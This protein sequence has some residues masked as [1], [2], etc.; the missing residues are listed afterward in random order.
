MDDDS[1]L[2]TGIFLRSSAAWAM[3]VAIIEIKAHG[4]PA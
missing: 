3:I 1:R 4:R 2:N